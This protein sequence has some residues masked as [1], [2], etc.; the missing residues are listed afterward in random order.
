MAPSVRQRNC[1]S[2]RD[3]TDSVSKEPSSTMS[4]I[5]AWTRVSTCMLPLLS[6]AGCGGR[7]TGDQEIIGAGGAA[8]TGGTT[9]AGGAAGSVGC[10]NCG[11][12]EQCFNQQFCVAKAVP[13]TEGWSIDATEVTRDQYS[14]W[15][16]TSPSTG[17]QPPECS[18]NTDFHA[19][20]TCMNHMACT[21]AGCGNHPQACV[22]W[23]SAHAYCMGVGKRLCGK[24]GGGANGYGEYA[25]A[26]KSQWFNACSA[27]GAKA[28]PYGN[29]YDGQSCNGWDYNFPNNATV[30]VGSI[31]ACQSSEGGYN[32]VYDLS[33]N[34]WEW[35]DSCNGASGHLD[36]CRLRGGSFQSGTGVDYL[37]CDFDYFMHRN[38]DSWFVGFRC[39]SP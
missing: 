36:E 28:F 32:G 11:P 35:E 19:D 30:P 23:C 24:I 38:I 7:V 2:F 37:R 21:G 5:W 4:S 10:G 26:A 6:M 14:S 39:C 1:H 16:A 29:T 20:A 15:L 8:G 3:G 33:G 22:D 27:N 12:L 18:W 31:A 25:D 34:V 13:I 9:D 17:G